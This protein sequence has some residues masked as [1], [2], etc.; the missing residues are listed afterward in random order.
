MFLQIGR[1]RPHFY[2]A[3]HPL[4]IDCDA[5][6]PH[7]YIEDYSCSGNVDVVHEARM[8]FP[9]GHSSLAFYAAV[10][11]VMYLQIRMTWQMSKLLRPFLQLLVI[12][13]AW[14]TALTRVSDYMHHWSDVLAGLTIGTLV[15][16]LTVVYVSNLR[17]KKIDTLESM[18]IKKP[19]M[20][21]N[22]TENHVITSND[23][24]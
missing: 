2:S 22:S 7:E 9:S 8:S 13:A 6:N 14:A 3:C 5:E 1:L 10:F 16:I 11:I 4:G 24:C 20:D 18:Y 12:T 23:L 17:R 19:I 21:Y 15:A